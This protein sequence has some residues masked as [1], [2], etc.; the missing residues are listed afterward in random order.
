M[1]I[2]ARHAH[3]HTVAVLL[4]GIE[5]RRQR[6]NVLQ[7]YGVRAE[8]LGELTRELDQLRAE[9]ATTVRLDS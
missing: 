5:L 8:G 9:L 6:M 7:T 3:Q 1:T 2:D 4:E